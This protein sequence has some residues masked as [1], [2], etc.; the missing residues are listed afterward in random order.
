[1]E[2]EKEDIQAHT[3]NL[4]H[5]LVSRIRCVESS[6]RNDVGRAARDCS[7]PITEH[8]SPPLKEKGDREA[9]GKRTTS[10]SKMR[11][12]FQDREVLRV[13]LTRFSLLSH[14]ERLR[15][16]VL[17]PLEHDSCLPIYEA[18]SLERW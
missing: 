3:I 13:L 9:P 16:D 1:M 11:C 18:S 6:R 17:R 5:S 4:P 12:F 10:V 2:L 14:D 7:T 8:E 15:L